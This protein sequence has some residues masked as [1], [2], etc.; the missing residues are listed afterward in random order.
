MASG[1]SDN[2]Q[3]R[4]K[5]GGGERTTGAGGICVIVKSYGDSNGSLGDGLRQHEGNVYLPRLDVS[6]TST[7]N[8]PWCAIGPDS[9][10]PLEEARTGAGPPFLDANL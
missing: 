7:N 8:N 2:E 10:E 9:A 5:A 3:D 6:A 4:T 1:P